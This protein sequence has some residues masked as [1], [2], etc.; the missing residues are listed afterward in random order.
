LKLAVI[1]VRYGGVMP[2]VHVL[3][4]E[5]ALGVSSQ[6][7]RKIFSASYR[8]WGECQLI[9]LLRHQRCRIPWQRNN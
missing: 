4:R 5:L 2:Q 1:P 7:T 9:P 6:P 3:S 8:T